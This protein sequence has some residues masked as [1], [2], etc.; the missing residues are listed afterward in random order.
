[1][2]YS[3]Y[4]D[5]IQTYAKHG[6]IVNVFSRTQPRQKASEISA[7]RAEQ[8]DIAWGNQIRSYVFHPYQL[9][10]DHRTEYE[11][12]QLQKVMD[13]DLEDFMSAMLKSAKKQE[14]F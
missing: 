5:W 4:N 9:V 1:M 12:S 14:F 8:K 6:T 7:L 13:G 11:T 3:E 2:I 10:K